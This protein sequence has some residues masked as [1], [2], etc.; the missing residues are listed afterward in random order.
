MLAVSPDG[1]R[2]ALGDTS[3]PTDGIRIM[4]INSPG[5]SSIGLKKNE[6]SR[7][8]RMSILQFSRPDQ[9]LAIRPGKGGQVAV[10]NFGAKLQSPRFFTL[11][12]VNPDDR[13][14]SRAVGMSPGGKYVAAVIGQALIFHDIETGQCVGSSKFPGD[15][16]SESAICHE[17][18]F[19][20]DGQRLATLLSYEGTSQLKLLEWNVATGELAHHKTWDAADW[21]AQSKY[22][23]FHE[24][25]P[26]TFRTEGDGWVLFGRLEWP[27]DAAAPQ[28]VFAGEEELRPRVVLDHN[29]VVAQ[30]TP[31]TALR[32]VSR[33]GSPDVLA[34]VPK[35]IDAWSIAPDPAAKMPKI[36][37]KAVGITPAANLQSLQFSQRP[38]RFAF[39]KAEKQV[40]IVD[41]EAARVLKR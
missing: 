25:H 19:S 2:L 30:T 28:Q 26:L 34:V 31:G 12:G 29:R 40:V 4:E 15:V 8:G 9:L 3:N 18:V 10:K 17:L 39:G 21:K 38:S 22:E 16:F 6:D 5:E 13:L 24:Q 27:A 32:F 1:T 14:W 11:S 7:F 41:M 35:P 33:A 36:T 23:T 37:A 20:P